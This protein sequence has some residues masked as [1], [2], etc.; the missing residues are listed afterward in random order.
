M[1]VQVAVYGTSPDLLM[2]Y[3][4]LYGLYVSSQ[5]VVKRT[6]KLVFVDSICKLVLIFK[7]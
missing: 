5:E 1:A 6:G 2:R 3:E 4:P 7:N